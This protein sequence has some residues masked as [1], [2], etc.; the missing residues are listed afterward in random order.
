[1]VESIVEDLW[2]WRGQE[3]LGNNLRSEGVEENSVDFRD[4]HQREKLDT[5]G[6]AVDHSHRER[7]QIEV[8]WRGLVE[9]LRCC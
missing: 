2:G 8:L 7:G 9:E 5:S 3:D 1:M 4:I 6:V